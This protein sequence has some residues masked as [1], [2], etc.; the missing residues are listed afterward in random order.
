M[1]SFAKFLVSA[2]ATVA[3]VTTTVPAFAATVP[4]TPTSS[5]AWLDGHAD[6]L[7]F[8]PS[9]RLWVW[10]TGYDPTFNHG[11]QAHVLVKNETGDW[12]LSYRLRI[13]RFTVRDISFSSNGTMYVTGYK[14]RVCQLVVASFRGDGSIKKTKVHSFPRTFCPQ[15]S[16]PINGGKIVVVGYTYGD[17]PATDT[18]IREYSLPFSV[19]KRPSREAKFSV[20]NNSF[21]AVAADGT[22]YVTQ[23]ENTTGGVD[24][25]APSQRGI[26]EPDHSFTVHPD[27]GSWVIGGL[28]ITNTGQVA[29]R[30][31]DTVSLY[32]PSASGTNLVPDTFYQFSDFMWNGVDVA[33]DSTGVMATTDFGR[34]FPIRFFFEAPP[35]GLRPEA[36]C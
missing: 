28:A 21:M 3:L 36:R 27:Y 32:S 23:G 13:K 17:G 9:G 22:V 33:F 26:V 31:K 8:D 7:Q 25:Y 34:D 10:N 2:A 19:K 18:A 12:V 16:T 24:V 5:L 15:Y 1:K 6:E 20:E 11:E 29:L 30:S 4:V 35:C 14:G